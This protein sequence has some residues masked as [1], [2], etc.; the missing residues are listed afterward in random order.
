MKRTKKWY[1]PKVHTGWHA[2]SPVGERRALVLKAHKGDLLASGRSLQSLANV[3]QE[4]FV[5]DE[6]NKDA[7]YFF[8]KHEES[9]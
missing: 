4:K 3:S 2:E 1:H 6:A 8:R 7:E 9:K 5:Q